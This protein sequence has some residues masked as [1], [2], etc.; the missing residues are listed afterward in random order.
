MA[1]PAIYTRGSLTRPVLRRPRVSRQVVGS[2][3][4]FVLRFSHP[5]W[6]AMQARQRGLEGAGEMRL[7]SL[8][9]ERLRMRPSRIIVGEVP[10]EECLDLLPAL[11]AG[12]PGMALSLHANSAREALV[13]TCTLPVTPVIPTL[14][15]P[16]VRLHI[17]LLGWVGR[18][19]SA[20]SP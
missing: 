9:T 8:F 15:G 18:G 7:R 12:F 4:L 16:G 14:D 10:A 11:N 3:R 1:K 6:V 13:K 20:R 2:C 17:A 19:R 5:G